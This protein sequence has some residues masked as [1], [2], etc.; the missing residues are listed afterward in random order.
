[1]IDLNGDVALVTGATGG[2]GQA[3]VRS[4]YDQGAK[5]V[6]TGTRETIL[7]ELSEQYDDRVTAVTCN[8]SI[9]EDVAQLFE[10]ATE[11]YGAPN[12]LVN[13]AGITQDQLTMRMKDDDFDQVLEINLRAAFALSRSA[14]RSMMKA[15]Y[16]RIVQIGSVVG[17]TGN[18]G[19]V[20][21]AAAKAGL[22]GLSKSLAQE[23]ASRNITVN[24]V[25]P[26]FIKTAMTSELG[27][28]VHEKLIASIPMGRMGSPEDVA[29]CVSFLVSKQAGYVTGQTLHVN[30]GMAMI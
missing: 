11:I 4:L 10:R 12:I 29:A 27:E 20:N 30:G 16:G 14:L 3:I 2:I 15:R 6:M 13:N 23:V 18:M 25:A 21:Y 26:G 22:I 28:T 5:I 17:T 24:V 7:N 19:Q 8:L 1:M 9:R